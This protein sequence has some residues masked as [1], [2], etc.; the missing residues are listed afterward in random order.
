MS[1]EIWRDI[2]KFEGVYEISNMGNV[3][4]LAYTKT[5]YNGG[6]YHMKERLLASKSSKHFTVKL[7]NGTYKRH[8]MVGRLAYAIFHGV[9]VQRNHL[10]IHKDGNP[11]NCRLDNLTLITKRNFVAAKMR[12]ASGFT[13]VAPSNYG[14]YVAKIDFECTTVTLHTSK[15]VE[16]CHKLYQAAKKCIEEYDRIKTSILSNSANNRL[17]NKKV[18]L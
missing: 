18:S 10:I 5:N 8:F 7:S 6:T 17:I 16:E 4:R 9:R 14:Q 11:L 2:P 12:S 13:G 1:K 3:K 15:D